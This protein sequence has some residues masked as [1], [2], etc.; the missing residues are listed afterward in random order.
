MHYIRF[1]KTPVLSYTKSKQSTCRIQALITVTSDLGDSFFPEDL[2]ISAFLL[3]E[4]DETRKPVHRQKHQWKA[5]MRSLHLQYH[6]NLDNPERLMQLMIVAKDI[7]DAYHEHQ[8]ISL[9]NIPRITSV[10]SESFACGKKPLKKEVERRFQLPGDNNMVIREE[11]GE[12]IARHIWYED[13]V[14]QYI[15]LISFSK[16]CRIGAGHISQ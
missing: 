8:K 13:K 10:W 7:E 16:G 3:Y 1:L 5:G 11:T 12:S 9:T 6:I 15:K 4:G 2:L 14:N